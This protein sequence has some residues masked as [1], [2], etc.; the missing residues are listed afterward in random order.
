MGNLTIVL[1]E[2]VERRLRIRAAQLYGTRK[3]ALSASIQKAIEDW[4]RAPRA[5]SQHEDRV[6]RALSEHKVVVE[7]RNLEE[8]GVKLRKAGLDPRD[9]EIRSSEPTK[10]VIHLGMRARIS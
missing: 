6:Y 1:D 3:G 4:L 10:R 7:A 2:E 5:P 8:L 9:V